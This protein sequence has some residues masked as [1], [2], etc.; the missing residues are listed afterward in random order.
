MIES[1][2]MTKNGSHSIGFGDD[3][4]NALQVSIRKGE[5]VVVRNTRVL[6]D[7]LME[8]FH[9]TCGRIDWQR[10]PE[11]YAR[12]TDPPRAGHDSL[13]ILREFIEN[14][15]KKAGVKKSEQIAWSGDNTEIDLQMD[16]STLVRNAGVLFSYAQHHYV[17]PLDCAWCI[18][19]TMEGWVYFGFAPET[20]RWVR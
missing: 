15:M 8:R 5:I 16:L 6:R 4:L 17:F 12:L 19:H 3:I 18:N 7:L 10:I 9:F 14:V 1:I 2:G 13:V 20:T 11:A